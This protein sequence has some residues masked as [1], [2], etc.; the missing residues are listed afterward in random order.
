MKNAGARAHGRRT[1]AANEPYHQ[2]VD[3]RYGRM[4]VNRHDA[5]VGRSLLLNL[6]CVP[7]EKDL[8]M[9]ATMERVR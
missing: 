3:A 4:I 2:V 1:V 8:P 7:R 9:T 6:L 5:Y